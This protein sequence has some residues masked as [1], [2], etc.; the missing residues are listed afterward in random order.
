MA[1]LRESGAIE[2]DADVIVFIYRDEYYNKENSPDKGLAEIIIGKQRNGPTG[3]IKL[4]VFGE[5]TRLDNHSQDHLRSFRRSEE[6]SAGT[7]GGSTWRTRWQARHSQNN[8]EKERNQ[9]R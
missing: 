1:D 8:K 9:N 3:A 6:R 2:R 4:T 7:E 5:Y